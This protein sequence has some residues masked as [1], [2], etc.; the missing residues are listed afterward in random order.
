MKRKLTNPLEIFQL[1][2]K[3]NCKQCGEKTCLAFASAVVMGKRKLHECPQL[4]Q[5]IIAQF[6]EEPE[7]RQANDPGYEYIEKLRFIRFKRTF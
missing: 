1:L 7:D 5:E 3:S 2:E 6:V 4:P